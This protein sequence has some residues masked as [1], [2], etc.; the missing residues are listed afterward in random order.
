LQL[1]SAVVPNG[2]R[3]LPGDFDRIK[4]GTHQWCY[5]FDDLQLSL[6]PSGMNTSEQSEDKASKKQFRLTSMPKKNNP[7]RFW[8]VFPLLHIARRI[9][10]QELEMKK[11]Y[12]SS[13]KTFTDRLKSQTHPHSTYSICWLLHERD[14][15]PS[16]SSSLLVDV[17][18]IS[19]LLSTDVYHD[20]TSHGKGLTPKSHANT[21]HFDHDE[22]VNCINLFLQ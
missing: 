2:R 10:G 15:L 9:F 17:Q 21:F 5:H 8:F 7:Y 20:P 22:S 1:R 13:P 18:M 19:H 16:W 12:D 4:E 6:W 14:S 11:L 3:K